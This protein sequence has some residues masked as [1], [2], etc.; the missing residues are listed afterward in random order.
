MLS[1]IELSFH[2][3]YL[4]LS[5]STA[6]TAFEVFND[7][8][9]KYIALKYILSIETTVNIIA[10]FAYS[11]LIK[12]IKT[13]NHSGIT[14]YRY[15]DWFVTTPLL[16]ISFTL[17]LQYLKNINDDSNGDSNKKTNTDKSAVKFDFDKLVIIILL[18]LIM[19]VFGFLGESNMIN[20]YS[21]C[22]LGFI[23]FIAIFYYIWKWYGDSIKNK[24]IFQIFVSIWAIYGIVYLF[25][26]KPKNISY[27]ILDVIAKVG[28]GL[29]IWFEVVQ[30]RLTSP[31]FKKLSS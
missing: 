28:F 16:L 26:N 11:S 30:L 9:D 13:P 4:V 25:P 23:P 2:F 24:K 21:G 20:R 5:G 7:Y 27:N 29:L 15:L 31:D 18:N 22:V 17:Y 6:L 8:P 3:A 12:L 10:S 19:L 1:F 14:N